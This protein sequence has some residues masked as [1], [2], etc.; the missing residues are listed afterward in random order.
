M[1]FVKAKGKGN[2]LPLSI[3]QELTRAVFRLE[4][5]SKADPCKVI[6]ELM[7]SRAFWGKNK[8][9]QRAPLANNIN[10][11]LAKRKYRLRVYLRNHNQAR[12]TVRT[13]AKDLLRSNA[14][15]TIN[16]PTRTRLAANKCN[17]W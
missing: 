8:S 1:P 10:N 5:V 17:P 9:S 13:I 3:F 7:F 16:P 2:G 12:N 11:T 4:A 6:L 15:Q 14:L